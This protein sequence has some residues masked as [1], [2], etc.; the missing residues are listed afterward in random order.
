[1]KYGCKL[2]SGDREKLMK[3]F[4][5]DRESIEPMISI[6]RIFDNKYNILNQKFYKKVD[7]SDI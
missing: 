1:M 2:K 7:V 5:S 4:P 6:A 3:S